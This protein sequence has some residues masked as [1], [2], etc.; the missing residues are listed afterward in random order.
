MGF[1]GHLQGKEKISADCIS[2]QPGGST[3]LSS[4]FWIQEATYSTSQ[5]AVPKHLLDIKKC[6]HSAIVR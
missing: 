1:K 6:S 5:D 2:H 4:P 3:T